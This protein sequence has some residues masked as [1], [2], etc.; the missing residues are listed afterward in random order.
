MSLGAGWQSWLH[1]VRL[2]AGARVDGRLL[3][4]GGRLLGMGGRR[5]ICTGLSC[6][7]VWNQAFLFHSGV[8]TVTEV[9]LCNRLAR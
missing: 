8:I 2:L 5:V 9:L 1:W 3:R 7:R 4:M 6:R